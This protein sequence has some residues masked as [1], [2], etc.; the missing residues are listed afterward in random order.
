MR[1][2]YRR[3]PDARF[4]NRE[5]ALL[6]KGFRVRLV[7]DRRIPADMRESADMSKWEQYNTCCELQLSRLK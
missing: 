3:V 4:G 7:G 2:E 6:K 5:K 1:R